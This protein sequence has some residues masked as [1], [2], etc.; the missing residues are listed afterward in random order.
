[1]DGE[2]RCINHSNKYILAVCIAFC[3]QRIQDNSSTVLAKS[4]GMGRGTE[5]GIMVQR[6]PGISLFIDL[7]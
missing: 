1:M 7:G 5:E 3:M 4:K 6:R 2:R